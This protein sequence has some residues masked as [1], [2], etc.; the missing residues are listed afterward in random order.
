MRNLP[1]FDDHLLRLADEYTFKRIFN[2]DC[3]DRHLEKE[4]VFNVPN[5]KADEKSNADNI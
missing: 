4:I 5:N 2:D 1:D 3:Y